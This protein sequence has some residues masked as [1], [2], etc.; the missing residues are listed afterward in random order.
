MMAAEV[1]RGESIMRVNLA[2][3][4]SEQWAA[5]SADAA[6]TTKALVERARA[7]GRRFVKICDNRGKMLRFVSAEVS[8]CS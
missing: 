7:R 3:S 1:C 4:E 2:R 6:E 5:D 8:A